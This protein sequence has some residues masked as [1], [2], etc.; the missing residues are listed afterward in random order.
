MSFDPEAQTF[1]SG[2]YVVVIEID[3]ETG[4]LT[5]LATTA[6]EDCGVVLD[7]V[8]VEGQ[9]HGSMMQGF[10]KALL[11]RIEYHRHGN[12]L[13]ANLASYRVPGSSVALRL[14]TGRLV[15]AAPS[16]P[17]GVKGTG[18][19]GCIG[20]PPAILN[21]AYD[22]LGHLGVDRIDLPLTPDRVWTALRRGRTSGQP[23]GPL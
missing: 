1:P 15:S 6:V 2:T 23:V 10:G 21:A 8:V 20:A 19:A 22:A 4:E 7:P 5:I 3:L 9:I 17:L 18:E 13:T 16:N 14:R 12:L 11:E